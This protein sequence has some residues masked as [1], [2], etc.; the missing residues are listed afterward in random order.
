[1]LLCL[2]FTDGALK[3][4]FGKVELWYPPLSVAVKVLC[5]QRVREVRFQFIKECEVR[6]SVR[7][8]DDS[9]LATLN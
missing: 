8:N 9:C 2:P 7:C 1:M 5:L 6:M 4:Y 3:G